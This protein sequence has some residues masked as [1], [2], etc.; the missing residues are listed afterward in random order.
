MNGTQAV[1]YNPQASAVINNNLVERIAFAGASSANRYRVTGDEAWISTGI[2]Y[3]NAILNLVFQRKFA[4]RGL[5]PQLHQTMDAAHQSGAPLFWT[6]Q[7]ENAPRELDRALVNHNFQAEGMVWGM[8]LDLQKL[9]ETVPTPEGLSIARVR[10]TEQVEQFVEILSNEQPAPPQV[11][12]RWAAFEVRLGLGVQNRWQRFVGYLDGEP[13]A[14]AAMFYGSTTAG[15]YHVA[16]VQSARGKGIGSVMTHAAMRD[17]RLR[18]YKTGILI[19]TPMGYNVYRRLGFQ[20]YNEMEI[21]VQE[22]E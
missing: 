17:A 18:G 4:A 14:T 2:P 19:S 5:H 3:P 15:L 22:A 21:F 13:V 7:P 16:T 12:D 6:V 1:D 20:A 11:L 10:T 9:P 8:A